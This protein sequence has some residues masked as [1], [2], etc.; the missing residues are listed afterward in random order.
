MTRLVIVGQA[1]SRKGDGRPFTGPSGK[2]L[3][4]LLDLPN[5][6]ALAKRVIL[7]N[8]LDRPVEPAASGRG[9]TYDR[10]LANARA[11]QLMLYYARQPELFV[12]LAAGKE[13]Y[14]SLIGVEGTFFKGK[15]GKLGP[16]QFVDVWCFP[17]PSGA[18]AYWNDRSRA[19]GAKR[20]LNRLL[21][22]YSIDMR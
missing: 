10:R 17:H 2:R 11:K 7:T 1:P 8:L 13:V 22:S 15:K 16:A 21:K 12:I 6:E 3:C 20:F 9:D 19:A 14:R 18:S 4:D 5:Y